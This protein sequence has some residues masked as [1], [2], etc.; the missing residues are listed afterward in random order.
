MTEL[1]IYNA[2]LSL[3]NICSQAG[4]ILMP[5]FIFVYRLRGALFNLR[6]GGA[7]VFEINNFGQTLREINNLLQELF[8]VNM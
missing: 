1:G 7:S 3:L 2:L 5:A 6:G 4:N 8:Y